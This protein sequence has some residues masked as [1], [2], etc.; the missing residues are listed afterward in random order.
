MN[1]SQ[2]SIGGISSSSSALNSRSG[3]VVSVGGINTSV[4]SSNQGSILDDLTTNNPEE[5]K[6]EDDKQQVIV[7]NVSP[8]E[9]QQYLY[10]KYNLKNHIELQKKC[11]E[12]KQERRNL[13]TKLDKFQKDFENNH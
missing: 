4:N 6:L 12:L 11:L 1:S 10:R 2:G 3:S 7:S 9:A 13:R 8:Q 5:Q